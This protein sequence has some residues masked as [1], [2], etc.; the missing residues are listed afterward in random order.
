[1]RQGASHL[2][3]DQ[4]LTP[5]Q[6]RAIG[7]IVELKV[8]DRTQLILDIFAQ[9]AQTR[10]GKLQV[11]LAQL[12][13]RL[14][15]LIQQNRSFSRLAGGIG[16]RG[17]GET[18]LEVDRRRI[19]D[20]ISRLEKD[21]LSVS[22]KRKQQ[23]SQRQK[24]KI[25]TVSIVGYTNVGKSTLL[26]T[27]TRSD[28]VAQDRLFATLDPS[29]RRLKFPRDMEVIITDT[30]GFIENLPKDLL[31]A[32]KATLEELATADLL[33]HVVD[34]SDNEYLHHIQ[35]VETILEQLNLSH[36]P[37]IYIYNKIDQISDFY[38]ENSVSLIPSFYVSAIDRKT[39]SPLTQYIQRLFD[40]NS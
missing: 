24:K 23:R 34:I 26:N 6:S 8:L 20:R 38:M 22:Q 13:Y 25:P 21:L 3:F 2:V 30:V 31:V 7:D 32:F 35:S 40:P 9:R 33:L 28:V 17:P 4:E 19:R 27:L 18:Q 14:P 36:I 39:L 29:S 10:E 11:E 16:G 5:S 1:M 37:A 15:R 12:K